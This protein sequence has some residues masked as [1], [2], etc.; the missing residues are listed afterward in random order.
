M[1]PC[2][3]LGL[4]GVEC[5]ALSPDR[6][7]RDMRDRLSVMLAGAVPARAAHRSLLASGPAVCC[8]LL[9]DYGETFSACL[10]SLNEQTSA[11]CKVP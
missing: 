5:C 1:E 6:D 7:G 10:S 9:P 4:T 11:V 2:W 3:G 8:T